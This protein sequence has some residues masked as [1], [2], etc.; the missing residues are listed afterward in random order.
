MAKPSVNKVLRY[1]RSIINWAG[2]Q[3]Y[4]FR[5][6]EFNQ[7]RCPQS[8]ERYLETSDIEKILHHAGEHAVMISTAVHTG[9]RSGELFNL[10]WE[11]VDIERRFIMVVNREGFHTKSY[12]NRIIPM[13][14]TLA[15]E[16]LV[17]RGS[18]SVG[19]VFSKADGSRRSDVRRALSKICRLSGVNFTLHDL[20]RTFASHVAFGGND[21]GA[22]QKI[23]GHSSI[24]TTMGYINH[25]VDRLRATVKS[26]E[27]IG[28]KK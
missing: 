6:L 18:K 24:N 22:V 9:M 14:E 20:R 10:C 7:L 27:G 17:Y 21:L 11:D 8:K 15:G 26:I 19:Y 13:T 12:K 16:L 4:G 2:S 28:A 23:L 1:T 5:P 3:G 25:Q